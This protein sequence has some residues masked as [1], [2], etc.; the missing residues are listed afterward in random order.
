METLTH[1]EKNKGWTSFHSWNPDAMGS[2]NSNF[3]T[4]KDGD[5]YLQNAK[6]SGRNL[7][8]NVQYNSKVV[9]VFNISPQDDKIFKTLIL[10]GT[11]PWDV[12]LSTNYTEGTIDKEEFKAKESRWFAYIRQNEDETD[13]NGNTVQGIGNIS[14]VSGEV[15]TVGN[16]PDQTSIGDMLFQ[17]QTDIPVAL[18]FVTAKTATTITFDPLENPSPVDSGLFCF[19]KKPSRIEGSEIRGYYLEVELTN[20]LAEAVELFAVNAGIVKS[21]V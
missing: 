5:L 20:E 13:L 7:F 21:Y 9:T 16:V 18:G 15:I 11:H 14:S 12:V 1:S 3:Y 6:N 2:L 4:V 8:Y 10:E 17:I 19:T